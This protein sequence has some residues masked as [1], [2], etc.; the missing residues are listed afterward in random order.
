MQRSS[1]LGPKAGLRLRLPSGLKSLSGLRPL[2]GPRPCASAMAAPAALAVAALLFSA[3]AASPGPARA[4]SSDGDGA[5]AV[6]PSGFGTDADGADEEGA[7]DGEGASADPFEPVNRATYRF[8][9]GVDA[10]LLRP[11]SLLW[12]GVVPGPVDRGARNFLANLKLPFSAANSALQ[13]DPNGGVRTMG[14]FGANTT[15]GLLGVFD[16]A[17]RW[18]LHACK[19]SYGETLSRWGV[20]SGPYLVVP[21]L[22]PSHARNAA[23]TAFEFVY[24]PD[25]LNEA[26]KEMKTAPNDRRAARRTAFAVSLAQARLDAEPFLRYAEENAL[27]EYVFV[28]SSYLQN[29]AERDEESCSEQIAAEAERRRPA[30][31]ERRAERAREHAALESERRRQRAVVSPLVP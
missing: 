22:G 26:L 27:D 1:I 16:P 31:D 12:D 11:L 6:L 28:R 30:P 9:K 2:L 21:F 29:S 14:R 20:G 23:G 19:E 7:A 18:G 8:N 24:E 3:F 10:V 13:G 17:S 25:L 4:Q 5:A 15:V